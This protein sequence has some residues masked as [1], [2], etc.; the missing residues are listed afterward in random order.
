MSSSLNQYQGSHRSPAMKF[1]DLFLTFSWQ[2]RNFYWLFAAW[3]YDILIFAGI[4]MG[5]MDFY[6]FLT[7]SWPVGT[8]NTHICSIGHLE[9]Y[10]NWNFNQS[11]KGKSKILRY[12]AS[13]MFA[14]WF[15][16]F[17][18]LTHWGRDKMAAIF[19]TPFSDAFSWMKMNEFR[20]KFHWSLFLR[21][22][23][24][25]SQHWFR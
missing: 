10:F 21:V 18:V 20:L 11:E 14:I 4:H 17:N 1:P 6:F 22:Q 9:T 16:D 7:F 25:I 2:S 8:L 13:T 19:Q 5:H 24:T 15:E 3:K 23:L 12:T